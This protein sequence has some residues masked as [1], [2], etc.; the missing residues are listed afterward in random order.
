MTASVCQTPSCANT[1]LNP[2]SGARPYSVG[3]VEQGG[4][5]SAGGRTGNDDGNDVCED[6]EYNRGRENAL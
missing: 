6:E 3:D 4:A 1:A 2:P 5:V